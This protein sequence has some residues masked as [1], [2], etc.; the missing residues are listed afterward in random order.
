MATVHLVGAEHGWGSN[1]DLQSNVRAALG[2]WLRQA[3]EAR[4]LT[5]AAVTAETKIPPRHLEALERGDA[6]GL[7]AFYQRAEVRAVARAVGVDED[8]ALVRLQ[9]VLAPVESDPD[10]LPKQAPRVGSEYTFLTLGA[11]IALVALVGLG[12]FERTSAGDQIANPFTAE[13][14]PLTSRIELAATASSPAV[15]NA[16]TPV[17]APL[18][19]GPTELVIRTQP[20]GAR[21]TVNGIGWGVSPV[22]IRHL[23][24]GDKRIR[25]TLDGYAP[26]ERSVVIDEGARQAVRIRL[27]ETD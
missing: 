19:S 7:P 6:M 2:G 1:A 10:T 9:A 22:T 17:A 3:R 8:Q 15:A 18:A 12:R 11:A 14:W 23:E 26:T 16:A 5:V 20:E 25:V 21:V 13:A 24:P 27:T 4:G